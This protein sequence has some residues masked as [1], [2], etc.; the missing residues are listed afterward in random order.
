MTVRKFSVADA[1]FVRSPG[2]EADIFA[3]NMIDQRPGA[4]GYGW[5]RSLWGEPESRGD[6]CRS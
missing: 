4:R 3:A 6:T 1:K 2:Q 5:V